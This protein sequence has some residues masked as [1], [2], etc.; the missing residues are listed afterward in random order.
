MPVKYV[1]IM[2]VICLSYLVIFKSA[3]MRNSTLFLTLLVLVL[4]QLTQG[5]RAV[6][7]NGKSRNICLLIDFST[8]KLH[9]YRS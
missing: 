5:R 6:Q 7:K 3:I 8:F 4:I 9:A 1:L 2:N